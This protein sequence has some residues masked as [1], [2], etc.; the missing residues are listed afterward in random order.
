MAHGFRTAFNGTL[1]NFPFGQ[2]S[3]PFDG[4]VDDILIYDTALTAGEINQLIGGEPVDTDNDGIADDWERNY[5]ENLTA[6]GKSGTGSTGIDSDG[7]GQSDGHE[8]LTDA[9]PLDSPDF[10][11]VDSITGAGLY[12]YELAWP[13]RPGIYCRIQYSRTLGEND[14]LTLS[15][16]YQGTGTILFVI[17]DASQVSDNEKLFFRIQSP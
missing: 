7:D 1:K 11:R 9:N 13:S 3:K 12:V 2:G 10:L 17:V 5:A 8:F 6:I 15:E 16:T 4:Q 14:W